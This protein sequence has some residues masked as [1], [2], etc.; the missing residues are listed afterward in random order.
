MQVP[1]YAL[2]HKSAI[3]HTGHLTALLAV[4][5]YQLRTVLLLYPLDSNYALTTRDF[6][7]KSTIPSNFTL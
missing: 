2:H 6:K 5:S 1:H 4:V 7:N 3:A